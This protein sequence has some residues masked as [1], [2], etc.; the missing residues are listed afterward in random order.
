MT[1]VEQIETTLEF[2]QL[3]EKE[4]NAGDIQQGSEKLWG[5]AVHAAIAKTEQLGWAHGSHRE[6]K[7]AV[8]NYAAR[9]NDPSLRWLFGL[10]EKFQRNFYNNTMPQFEIASDRHNVALFVRRMVDLTSTAGG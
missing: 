1:V 5:V 2:M 4:L 3:A 10:S 8:N 7:S 6:L 9:I